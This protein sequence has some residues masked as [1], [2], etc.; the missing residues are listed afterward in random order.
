M[1]AKTGESIPCLWC[2]QAKTLIDEQY[3][4]E[5]INSVVEIRQILP[6]TLDGYKKIMNSDLV[7][8]ARSKWI[9]EW[10]ARQIYIALGNFMTTASNT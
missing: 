8:G 5:Y 9:K 6:E 10:A 2:L 4:Q 7:H 1:E 3:I